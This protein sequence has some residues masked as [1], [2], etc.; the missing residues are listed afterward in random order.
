MSEF[1]LIIHDQEAPYAT[2]TEQQWN[3]VFEAHGRF[4]QHVAASGGAILEGKAIQPTRTAAYVRGGTVSD[5]PFGQE[6]EP[7]CGF[8][9]IEARDRDHA[10]EIAKGCPAAYGGVEVRPVMPTPAAAR[11]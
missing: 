5:E 8:Y 9:L 2:Y 1:L 10:V 3:Q 7:F 6:R 4:A 11:A